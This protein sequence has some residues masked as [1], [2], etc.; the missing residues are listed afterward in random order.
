MFKAIIFDL[1]GLLV[2][3]EVISYQ[4]YKN[5]LS[6]YGFDFTKEEYAQYY[7]GKTEFKNVS[8][9]IEKY[10]LPWSLEDG[11][12]KVISIEKNLISQGVALKHGAKELLVY[13]KENKYKTA[14]A[15]SSHKER[16]LTILKQHNII[17]Y[18]DEFIFADE[19]QTGKP[20]PDIF[21]KTCEKLK[22][23][24][25]NCLILEDSETGIQA[26]YAA[27]IPVICIPDIKKPDKQF[28]DKTI[29]K[30]NSLEKVILYLKK[31]D[32]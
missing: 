18:F 27:N 19:V 14:I 2:D 1:D 5:I 23:K 8:N 4:I 6:Q 7:S 13:L 22:E 9:L 21:L 12:K 17:D 26:A 3:T 25:E 28:L 15:S 10:K 16:A 29:A 11:L 20:N 32:L 24:P 31:M 30:F